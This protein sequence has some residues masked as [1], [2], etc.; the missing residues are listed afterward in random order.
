MAPAQQL[1]QHAQPSSHGEV[2]ASRGDE[3]VSDRTPRLKRVRIR[4]LSQVALLR[5]SGGWARPL[6]K[7]D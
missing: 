5:T 3:T 4:L 1:I 6:K 7:R 2:Y